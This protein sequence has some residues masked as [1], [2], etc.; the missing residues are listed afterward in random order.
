MSLTVQI[1]TTGNAP[2]VVA[3]ISKAVHPDR[4]KPIIG[5]SAVVTVRSHLFR[6]NSGRPN[7]LGGKRT[8]FYST[9]ARGTN[10][11]T[12][13]DGII[14]SIGSG[15][16][17]GAFSHRVTG[18]T[19]RPKTKKYLTIPAVAEA[20]GK[21]AGEFD[22]LVL[23]FGPSGQPIALAHALFRVTRTKLAALPARLRI[24]T[25]K[26]IGQHGGIVFWLKKSVT[27]AP[28]PS[29]MPEAKEIYADA[30]KQVASFVQ[31]Q[32]N[33]AAKSAGGAS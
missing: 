19:I 31:A 32:A 24:G 33:R 16:P 13:A 18:G 7:A 28:D 1:T 23:V 26:Q 12:V 15:L 3:A 9:A 14:L 10:F 22:D 27:H 17:A 8:N 25:T 30:G 2:R 11:T 20:H 6:I 29:V 5:R 21:T 4:L